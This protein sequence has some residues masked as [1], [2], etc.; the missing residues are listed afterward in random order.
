MI[1]INDKNRILN[2][3]HLAIY[4]ML[5]ESEER[6]YG[7]KLSHLNND[8]SLT[9]G[10]FQFAI[11]KKGT[12][13]YEELPE[14]MKRATKLCNVMIRLVNSI[15]ETYCYGLDVINLDK[16]IVDV[17]A[18]LNSFIV[19]VCEANVRQLE[20]LEDRSTGSSIRAMKMYRDNAI[21]K[22]MFETV[23]EGN[24]CNRGVAP[25]VLERTTDST[26]M[27]ESSEIVIEALGAR[28]A[29][30]I[31][32][33]LYERNRTGSSVNI[34][35]SITSV[36]TGG[37]PLK[38]GKKKTGWGFDICIKGEHMPVYFGSTDQ[39]FLYAAVLMASIEGYPLG[40]RHFFNAT[41]QQIAWLRQKY[42]AFCFSNDF[43]DWY[44]VVG[45]NSAHRIDDAVSKIKGALWDVLSDNYK[46]AYYYLCITTVNNDS[47]TNPQSRYKVRLGTKKIIIDPVIKERIENS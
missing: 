31:S 46:E 2:L 44:T 47:R 8:V 28:S 38:N 26:D 22:E 24:V 6:E 40:R 7:K 1:I 4:I 35:L 5:S 39:T 15:H 37:K 20:I 14:Y 10:I 33:E 9:K 34:T 16:A 29:R 21:V 45:K 12:T 25:A 30:K 17:K 36:P 41:D 11:V 3:N 19:A 23:L 18:G 43:R 13:P 42:S 32:M 27:A